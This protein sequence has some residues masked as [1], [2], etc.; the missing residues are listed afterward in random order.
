LEDTTSLNDQLTNYN[1]FLND[2]VNEHGYLLTRRGSESDITFGNFGETHSKWVFV[3]CPKSD[4]STSEI[5]VI[6]KHDYKPIKP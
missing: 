5:D 6:S 3:Y 1:D 2:I 4:A